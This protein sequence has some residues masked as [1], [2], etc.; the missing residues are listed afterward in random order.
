MKILLGTLVSLLALLRPAVS[1]FLHRQA[2]S[3]LE[4]TAAA[5]T[6]S[7]AVVAASPAPA[8]PLTGDP[9]LGLA[10]SANGGDYYTHAWTGE[11]IGD[12]ARGTGSCTA[13]RRTLQC[14][15]SGVRDPTQ[16]KGCSQ[17]VNS[18]ESGFCECGDYA[19]FAAV[20]CKHRPFTCEIMCLK[21]ALLTG[22]PAIYKNQALGPQELKMMT[23]QLMWANQTDLTAMRAM[24]EDIY[25]F[26]TR[27]MEYTNATADVAKAS[28]E[29]FL[30]MMKEAR[31]EDAAV[32]AKEL[33]EY[34]KSV[35][36]KPWLKI[37]ENGQE[38]EK[39]GQA[40]QDKVR[41]VLPFDPVMETN[42][43]LAH[44]FDS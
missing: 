16:D 42:H 11:N 35:E 4:R 9:A 13:F 14:N 41:E 10:A 15:P 39:T 29:K 3:A 23:D 2:A 6:R 5:K 33:A 26:M 40:I 44:S 32:A 27:A 21:F 24:Q 8:G 22:K 17:V 7:T 38:L 12:P 20:D 28:M 25:H 43:H 30:K 36:D 31:T 18:D 19:Q 37:W 34:H 1:R